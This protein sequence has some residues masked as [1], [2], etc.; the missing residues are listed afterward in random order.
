MVRDSS[1]EG[2]GSRPA[3]VGGGVVT[4]QGRAAGRGDPVRAQLTDGAGRSQGP[5]AA[6]GCGRE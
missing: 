3:G 4:R 5:V 6:A 1:A 2:I